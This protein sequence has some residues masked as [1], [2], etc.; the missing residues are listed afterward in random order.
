MRRYRLSASSCEKPLLR[1]L[2]A[3]D[4]NRNLLRARIFSV[5]LLPRRTNVDGVD[6]N[7]KAL[8]AKSVWDEP[9]ICI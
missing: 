9:F 3:D 5:L 1:A 7:G 6:R 8:E 4:S 2:T